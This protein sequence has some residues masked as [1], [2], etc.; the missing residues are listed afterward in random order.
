MASSEEVNADC[1]DGMDI[2]DTAG[3]VDGVPL[4]LTR[5]NGLDTS[6]SPA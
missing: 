6:I 1:E 4:V 2:G 3:D 5:N